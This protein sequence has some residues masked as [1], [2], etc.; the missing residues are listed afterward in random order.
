MHPMPAVAP[1]PS[2]PSARE[3]LAS[4]RGQPHGF[5]PAGAHKL[6]YRKFGRGPDLVFVHGW[7]LHAATFRA[8]APLLGTRFTCHLFDLPGSGQTQSPAGAPVDLASH[9]IALRAAI[10]ALGLRIYGLVAHDSGGFT[11]RQLAAAD[12][13]V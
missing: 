9:A 2:D 6:A 10:D 11:A 8:V 3:V 13:R 7:P 5:I 12:P 4:F 1:S